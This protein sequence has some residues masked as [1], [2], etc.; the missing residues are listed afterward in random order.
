MDSSSVGASTQA[1]FRRGGPFFL[2]AGPCVLEE[3]R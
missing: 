1:L 3:T 2:I